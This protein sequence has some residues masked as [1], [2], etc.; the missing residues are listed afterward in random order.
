MAEPEIFTPEKP[1]LGRIVYYRDQLHGD[2]MPAIVTSTNVQT[3]EN[4]RGKNCFRVNLTVF[5]DG[6][7]FCEPRSR[8]TCGRGKGQWWHSLQDLEAEA[9][10]ARGNRKLTG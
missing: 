7:S 5:H 4:E 8:V 9:I 6:T 3:P 1:Y 10:I 2:I